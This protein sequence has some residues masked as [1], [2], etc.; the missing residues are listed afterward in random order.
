MYRADAVVR[1][2]RASL[3]AVPRQKL[4]RAPARA[5]PIV[6]HSTAGN[7]RARAWRWAHREGDCS[8]AVLVEEI[9]SGGGV[10]A[11]RARLAHKLG[12]LVTVEL[13]VLGRVHSATTRGAVNG[14]RPAGW[15]AAVLRRHASNSRGVLTRQRRRERRGSSA[16]A[17][18]RAARPRR[19]ARATMRGTLRERSAGRANART[20]CH[21]NSLRRPLRPT[22]P[23]PLA[24]ATA[25]ST[26]RSPLLMPRSSRTFAC[27]GERE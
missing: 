6:R 16:Y 25:I 18:R 26:S 21:T 22:L 15:R 2:P 1:Q 17:P 9:E 24:S 20:R 7:F 23:S 12:E 10:C 3:E 11:G 8:R 19:S 27:E 13:A 14:K 5:Q 4:L